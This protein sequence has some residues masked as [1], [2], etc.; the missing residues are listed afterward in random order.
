VRI[1]TE[2]TYKYSVAEL[3]LELESRISSAVESKSFETDIV[4]AVV[5]VNCSSLFI[6][7]FPPVLTSI[8]QEQ[9]NA[10]LLKTSEFRVAMTS[11]K[12]LRF[13]RTVV[14]HVQSPSSSPTLA[15]TVHYAKNAVGVT[16]GDAFV[17]GVSSSFGILCIGTC[18]C[19]III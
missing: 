8:C 12:L 16:G 19:F 17:I 1:F 15:P 4:A 18:A 13:F 11:A 9:Y 7:S 5:S 14:Q 6:F 10:T 3:A 2:A